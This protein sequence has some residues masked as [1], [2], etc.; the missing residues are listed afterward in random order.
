MKNSPNTCKRLWTNTYIA[1]KSS[2]SIGQWV[3][4]FAEKEIITFNVIEHKYFQTATNGSAI[5]AT[6]LLMHIFDYVESCF[7]ASN[8][9]II[10]PKQ[11]VWRCAAHI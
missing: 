7:H 9:L 8:I 10:V 2:A 6:T 3:G 11:K 1:D 4:L 5:I